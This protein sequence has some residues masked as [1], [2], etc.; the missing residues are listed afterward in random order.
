MTCKIVPIGGVHK[1]SQSLLAEIMNDPA[2]KGVVV[3]GFDDVGGMSFAHFDVSRAEM[4]YASVTAAK[5]AT[6]G[7]WDE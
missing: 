7:E 1:S 3:F 4:A 5:H 2:V 6:E